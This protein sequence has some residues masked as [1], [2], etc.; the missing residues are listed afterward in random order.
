MTLAR[1]KL[2]TE[3]PLAGAALLFLVAYA[4]SVI[5]D[6]AGPESTVTDWIMNVV[7]AMFVVD[8]VVS[9]VLARP[10]GRWFVRHLYELLIVVLPVL[11]P[12]RLLRLV[13]LLAVLHRTAGSALRGRITLYVGGSALLLVFVAGLAVLDAEQNASGSNI[14]TFGDALWWAFVTITTVG[15]GDYYPVTLVGRLIAVGL[16]ISGIALIG[17]VTATFA[18]WFIEIIGRPPVRYGDEL[19]GDADEVFASVRRHDNPDDGTAPAP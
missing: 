19:A 16:M 5:G 8:Y 17:S 6:F 1:W 9:L 2:L 15:Y 12:L 14:R 3:W 7:W 4:C 11:R 13:T 10:R 18:S